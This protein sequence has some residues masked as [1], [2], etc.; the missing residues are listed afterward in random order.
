MQVLA[1]R[2]FIKHSFV[3]CFEV[4]VAHTETVPLVYLLEQG[5]R[6]LGAVADAAEEMLEIKHRVRLRFPPLLQK[7]RSP[8]IIIKIL[9]MLLN[10]FNKL[11][12]K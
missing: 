8:I 6:L 1:D 9:L 7:Q 2:A 5:R 10:H 12:E 4:P 3:H 11:Q